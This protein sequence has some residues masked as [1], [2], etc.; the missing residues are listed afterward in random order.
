MNYAK[1]VL[2]GVAITLVVAFMIVS[3][4]E[5]AIYSFLWFP[6]LNRF[7]PESLQYYPVKLYTF[8]DR[9]LTRDVAVWDS[10][11]TYTLAPMIDVRHTNREFDVRIRTNSLG[12]RDDEASLQAPDIIAIGDSFTMGFGVDQDEAF[13]QLVE[14]KTGLKVLNAGIESYGTAR[15][16]LLT[17]RI[18]TSNMKYLIVQYCPNDLA[19]NASFVMQRGTLNTMSREKFDSTL[20]HYLDNRRY[21]FGKFVW[22]IAGNYSRST[23]THFSAGVLE[24]KNRAHAEAFLYALSRFR[25]NLDGVNIIVLDIVDLHASYTLGMDP[26][27]RSDLFLASLSELSKDRKYSESIRNMTLLRLHEILNK[28]DRYI[29]DGH[30][31]PGGHLK[32]ADSIVKH[33]VSDSA[34]KM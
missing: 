28:S 3:L 9:D 16:V 33:I 25:K 30:L 4:L 20:E 21:F 14:R 10:Q 32:I 24:Q 2:V 29:L 18:D 11:L 6:V 1:D 26:D 27:Y 12:L 15:E 19:E 22:Y 31:N 23:D 7:L 8:I 5:L 17:R 13:P 34:E